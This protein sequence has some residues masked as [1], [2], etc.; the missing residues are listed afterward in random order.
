MQLTLKAART[1]KGLTQEEMAD[2]LG[3]SMKTYRRIESEPGWMRITDALKFV[4]ITGVAMES[5]FFDEDSSLTPNE[6]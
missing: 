6:Q 3:M 1:N 2:M 5:L 4:E